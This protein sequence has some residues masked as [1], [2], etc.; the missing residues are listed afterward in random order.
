MNA[1]T[2]SNEFFNPE[3]YDTHILAF[4]EELVMQT[5]PGESSFGWKMLGTRRLPGLPDRPIGSPGLKM[6][7]ITETVTLQNGHKTVTYRASKKKPLYCQAMI[8]PIC[9]KFKNPVPNAYE[10]R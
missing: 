2:D 10:I 4:V 9:G 6:V 8:Q 1:I 7:T 5:V 3:D